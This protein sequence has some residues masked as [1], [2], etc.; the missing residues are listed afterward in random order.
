MRRDQKMFPFLELMIYAL[1]KT[2][3][4]F[5][6]YHRIYIYICVCGGV[7]GE[8]TRFWVFSL[9][10]W[11]VQSLLHAKFEFDDDVYSYNDIA[12]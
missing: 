4:K 12:Y 8:T 6:T 2:I 1:L 3:L 10:S 11:G 7:F 5:C 9:G